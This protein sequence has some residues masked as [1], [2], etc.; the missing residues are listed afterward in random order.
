MSQDESNTSAPPNRPKRERST[1]YPGVDL[2]ESVKLCE[3]ID[4]LGVDGLTATD[5]ASALGYKNIKTNTFSARLSATR[6][7]GLLVLNDEG[8]A[9]TPL[10]RE[11]LHP[12]DPDDVS[13]LF[14]QAW[15]KPPLYAELAERLGGKRVPDASI[16]GNVLYHNHQIIASAKQSAAEAFLSSARYAGV[17]GDDQVLR[18]GGPAAPGPTT[19]AAEPAPRGEEPATPPAPSR[20]R[21]DTSADARIDL[22]LWGID[23]GKTIRLRCPEAI[24]RASFDRFLQAFRLHVRVEEPD[25]SDDDTSS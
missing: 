2:A 19:A 18:P 12:V 21:P 4:R 7:F 23:Q 8:Y 20:T 5:I 11:I 10:A 1:R 22:K 16:L 6:Q 15:L 3:T 17:L 25:E 14:R 9:L 13:R 24:S